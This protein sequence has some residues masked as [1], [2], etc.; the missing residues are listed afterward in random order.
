MNLQTLKINQNM[1]IN[2]RSQTKWK[3]KEKYNPQTSLLN[4]N[5][6]Y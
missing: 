5:F 3:Q 4:P 1:N 6:N 2:Q